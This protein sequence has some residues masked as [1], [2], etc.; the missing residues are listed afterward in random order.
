MAEDQ[1]G[2]GERSGAEEGVGSAGKPGG[3]LW[4]EQ[5]AFTSPGQN[6]GRLVHADDFSDKADV[7]RFTGEG[8]AFFE[9]PA[10]TDVND[11]V[12][13]IDRVFAGERGKGLPVVAYEIL[14]VNEQPLFGEDL[15]GPSKPT[16]DTESHNVPAYG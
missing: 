16:H 15:D 1:T 12:N 3:V 9:R 6:A 11:I 4:T 2:V 14:T 13:L 8:E 5:Y 7:W 10:P